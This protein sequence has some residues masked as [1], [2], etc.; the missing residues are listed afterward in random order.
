MSKKKRK[1]PSAVLLAALLHTGAGK[2]RE[3]RRKRDTRRGRLKGS[4]K[5]K[6]RRG[7]YD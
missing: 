7:E 5:A 2:H 4:E 6:F 1:S 3:G